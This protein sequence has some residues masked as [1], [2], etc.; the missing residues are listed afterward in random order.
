MPLQEGLSKKRGLFYGFWSI[1]LYKIV[2]KAI[3]INQSLKTN[4]KIETLAGIEPTTL[5][6]GVQALDH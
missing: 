1:K 6:F 4:E 5:E 2:F 3:K